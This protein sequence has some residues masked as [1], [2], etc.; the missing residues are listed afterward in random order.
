MALLHSQ[1]NWLSQG[2]LDI[3][4]LRLAGLVPGQSTRA[5]PL[6]RLP[7]QYT[8]DEWRLGW[9][10][11]YGSVIKYQQVGACVLQDCTNGW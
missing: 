5:H 6:W 4:V 9:Q 7:V 10:F 1:P 11:P 8:I 2:C 3:I